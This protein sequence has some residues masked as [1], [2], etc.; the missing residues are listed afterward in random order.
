MKEGL[1]SQVYK[2]VSKIP[3]GSVMTYAQVAFS[4]Q[5]SKLKIK[6]DKSKSKINPK[7]VGFAL[8][9]NKDL[10]VPCHRVV[11]KD[12]RIA[13]NFAFGGAEE[14]KDDC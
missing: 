13:L 2:I 4:I 12:G 7:V 1:F 14:Q 8:H 9:A 5:N 6:N 3:K 10:K 11:N